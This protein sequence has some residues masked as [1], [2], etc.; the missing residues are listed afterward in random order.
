MSRRI[1]KK[2]LVAHLQHA[3]RSFAD[4]HLHVE[5]QLAPLSIVLLLIAASAD[6]LVPKHPDAV[7]HLR[8][9]AAL[10]VDGVD[11]LEQQGVCVGGGWLIGDRR[12]CR[13]WHD[14]A[15]RRTLAGCRRWAR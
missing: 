5:P 13:R 8:A 14:A 9:D 6:Q 10:L 4:D 7:A 15:G 2:S 1:H 12:P 3:G 11:R